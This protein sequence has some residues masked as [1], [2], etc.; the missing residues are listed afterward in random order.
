MDG[1]RVQDAAADLDPLGGLRHRGEQN[2]RAP[3][4]QVVAD[5]ELVDAG[6]LGG[7]SQGDVVGDGQVVVQA[8]AKAHRSIRE[9]S[10]RGE[11]VGEG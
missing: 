5:P 1:L 3:E 4:K 8:Q 6:T 11:P 9:R 2:G 10:A 7:A